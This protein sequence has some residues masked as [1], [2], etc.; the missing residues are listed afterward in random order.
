MPIQFAKNET[1]VRKFDYA[2]LGYNKKTDDYT[3]A[4]SLIVT[5]RRLIHQDVNEQFGKTTI[6]RHE[7]PIDHAKFV[8]VSYSKTSKPS[9]LVSA[10]FFAIFAVAVFFLTALKDALPDVEFLQKLPDLLFIGI[11]GL[12]GMIAL[13]NVI[14]YFGSKRMMLSC[15]VSTDTI[16]TTILSNTISEGNSSRKNAKKSHS[17]MQMDIN[18]PINKQAAKELADGLGAAI[19]DAIEMNREAKAVAPAVAPIN[20]TLEMPTACCANAIAESKPDGEKPVD[21][22]AVEAFV[23][24][25]EEPIDEAAE[26][27][28]EATVAETVEETAEATEESNEVV[29]EEAP[30]EEEVLTEEVLSTEDDNKIDEQN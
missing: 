29:E 1:V 16:I 15:T 20:V 30:A 4:L 10:L 8:D 3:S 22:P 6:V 5:N 21:E 28:V 14:R 27:A 7:M 26:E 25:V 24:A 2:T 13:I 19:I 9:L 11:S 17:T 18:I 12:L 23:E